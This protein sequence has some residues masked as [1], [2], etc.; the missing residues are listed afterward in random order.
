MEH[1][2]STA[3]PEVDQVHHVQETVEDLT[4]AF[5]VASQLCV[6]QEAG[7]V[8]PP[9]AQVEVREGLWEG[10]RDVIHVD[11]RGQSGNAGR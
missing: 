2:G 5:P 6:P 3:E 8:D 11:D 1:N 4:G 9:K 7:D 10:H